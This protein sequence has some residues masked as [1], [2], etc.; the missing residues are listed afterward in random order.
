MR[1]LHPRNDHGRQAA[2]GT[3]PQPERARDPAGARRQPLSLHRLPQHRQGDPGGGQGDG[4]RRRSQS[5]GVRLVRPGSSIMAISQMVGAS[6]KRREDP[7]LRSEEHT[8]ELQSP[9]D[10]V[11]RLL[12]EKKKKKKKQT[13]NN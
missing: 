11:C 4:A 10:L 6:I 3:Q 9:Y 2:A 8:S 1:L 7:K 5:A 12:L 13:K